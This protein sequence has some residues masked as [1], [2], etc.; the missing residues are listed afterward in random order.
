MLSQLPAASVPPLDTDIAHE[1]EGLERLRA[2]LRDRCAI[3]YPAHKVLLLRS[4]LWQEH[5]YARG[6]GVS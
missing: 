4:R 2:W 5:D 1:S 6:T 3:D